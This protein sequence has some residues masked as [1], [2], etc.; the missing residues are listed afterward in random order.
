MLVLQA[1]LRKHLRAKQERKVSKAAASLNNGIGST[2]AGGPL[3]DVNHQA[4][5][6][7]F[8]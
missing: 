5:S 1:L 2:E 7:A 4:C 8:P 3:C 6:N